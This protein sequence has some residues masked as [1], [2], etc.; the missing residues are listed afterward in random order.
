[1]VSLYVRRCRCAAGVLIACAVVLSV[2]GF[3][4]SLL[5][6]G[7]GGPVENWS[8]EAAGGLNPFDL[9]PLLPVAVPPLELVPGQPLE[10][11]DGAGDRP[12]AEF[13]YAQ[14][15]GSTVVSFDASASRGAGGEL[16]YDWWFYEDPDSPV[17]VPDGGANYQHAF[18]EPGAYLVQLAVIDAD[19]DVGLARDTIEVVASEPEELSADFTIEQLVAVTPLVDPNGDVDWEED[20]DPI[21][22]PNAGNPV[23]K[24]LRIKF[25]APTQGNPAWTFW[26]FGDGTYCNDA[27]AYHQCS[28]NLTVTLTVYNADWTEWDIVTKT[29]HVDEGAQFLAETPHPGFVFK[30]RHCVL[31][32]SEVWSIS[33]DGD[34]GWCD[35]SDPAALAPI[36]RMPIDGI[37]DYYGLAHANG[38]LYVAR[39]TGGVSVYN[40]DPGDF[41][42]LR[43][44]PPSELMASYVM[45]VAAVEDI[46]YVTSGTSDIHAFDV[47]NL[48]DPQP[49]ESIDVGFEAIY[50]AQLDDVALVAHGWGSAS[51]VVIDV[52]QP[53][54]PV[55]ACTHTM[56]AGRTL[57]GLAGVGGMRFAIGA[58][59]GS[60]VSEVVVP[61][62]D[63]TTLA[64][65]P[66]R[67]LPFGASADAALTRGRA[68]L[69]QFETIRKFNVVDPAEAVYLQ[70][71]FDVV[72][73]AQCAAFVYDPDGPGGPEPEMPFFGYAF[74]YKAYLP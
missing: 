70:Q 26:D 42:L 36:S 15:P 20:W 17:F 44:M 67:E 27:I 68:Y 63:Q 37:A 1:M 60:V 58:T 5:G 53:A 57:C 21:T 3:G 11:G 45:G 38:R 59:G 23:E 12:I 30:P 48:A 39:G 46:L 49:R 4:Q 10:P 9:R 7:H 72:T 35:V 29:V 6:A 31:D 66:V 19:G 18:A 13:N 61:A 51:F 25:V 71:E 55:I 8:L 69:R 22:L 56:E 41:Y 14:A 64:L 74:G 52:R 40:A 50:M 65:A 47:A 43:E 62:D 2:P 33:T 28:R 16:Q 32:G 73:P 54:L 34:I 24:G